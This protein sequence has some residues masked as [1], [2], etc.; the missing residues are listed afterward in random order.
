MLRASDFERLKKKLTID[1]EY[2][3]RLN[4]PTTG[5]DDE[6]QEIMKRQSVIL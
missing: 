2:W 5:P 6:V 1:E 4:E 3:A